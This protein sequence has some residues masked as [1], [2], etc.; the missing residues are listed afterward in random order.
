MTPEEEAEMMAKRV[1]RL[2]VTETER[3]L[4]LE[5]MRNARIRVAGMAELASEKGI[6]FIDYQMRPA[7]AFRGPDGMPLLISAKCTHLGCTIQSA[8]EGGGR[9]LCPCHMSYFDLITGEPSAGSPAKAPLPH[10]GWL[11]VDSEGRVVASR[12]AQGTLEG[13]PDPAKA[14]QCTVFI[15]R[16]FEE[17]A[18]S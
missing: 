14:A 9:I 8:V 5:R 10:L 7:L 17:E 15:A 4:E 2:K 1:K 18:M 16:Q 6:Y 11:L 12:N 3:E 13:K